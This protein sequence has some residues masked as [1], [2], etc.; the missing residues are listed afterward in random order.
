MFRQVSGPNRSQGGLGVGLTLTKQLV[1]MHGGTIEAHSGGENQGAEFVIRLP[2][3]PAEGRPDETPETRPRGEVP[4]LRVLVVDDNV[5]LV[6]MLALMVEASGHQVRKAFD[7]RSAVSAALEYQPH[8]V[9]LDVGMPDMS[10]IDVAKELRRHPEMAATRIV[11]L[12]GWG[13][14]EDRHR[15]ADAGFDDHVTKPADPERLR[16][17]LQGFGA[18]PKR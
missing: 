3:A 14:A 12:T 16:R 7:G 18:E 5:D 17:L 4:C 10:G 11:A 9:L 1:E 8:V 2:L 15:T 13:Q 6:E